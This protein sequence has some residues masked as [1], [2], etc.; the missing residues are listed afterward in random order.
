MTTVSNETSALFNDLGLNRQETL[1]N[2]KKETLGQSD[3]LALLTTQLANQDPF[4]PLDNKEFIAQ[5]AQFSS[6][7]GME[8]LNK[9][10]NTLATSLTGSQALQ[11]SALV[12]RS[13][14]V[15]TS[16]GYL[17]EGGEIEGRLSLQQ[18]TQ[19]IWAEVKDQSGQVVRR[20]EIGSYSSG[21]LDFA[22]DG[23]SD[24]GEAMPEG[25]Y[26]I[27]VYGQVG[28]TTEQ[29]GTVIKAQVNSVNLAGSNGQVVLN[30][31][32]LGSVNL[33]DIDEIGL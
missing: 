30:L 29:L 9:N 3:F 15:P 24:S 26:S 19:N 8:E 21:D 18:A 22:W 32:G 6:L 27:N 5:M 12:G 13:V 1:E 10:F 28:G 20:F 14:M 31:T 17:P 16:M 11:A 33:G 2:G 23:L 7:S 25:P 4:D